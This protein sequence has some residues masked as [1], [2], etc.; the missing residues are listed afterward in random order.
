MSF[1]VQTLQ[2]YFAST[3]A[4][5]SPL[6]INVWRYLHVNAFIGYM[7]KCTLNYKPKHCADCCDSL[8]APFDSRHSLILVTNN[9]EVWFTIGLEK[10]EATWKSGLL[11]LSTFNYQTIGYPLIKFKEI[12]LENKLLVLKDKS[13]TSLRRCW[14]KRHCQIILWQRRGTW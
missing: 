13:A 5:T 14:Q 2:T 3:V 10:K 11:Y 4:I 1:L 8:Q 7:N 6:Q 9:F 12:N